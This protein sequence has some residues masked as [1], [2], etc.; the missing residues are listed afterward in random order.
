[1]KDVKSAL[2][3]IDR[4]FQKKKQ[5]VDSALKDIASG[6]TEIPDLLRIN[7]NLKTNH[8]ELEALL[9]D[10]YDQQD[11]VIRV[12]KE[13]KD[14]TIPLNI[15]HR[16]QEVEAFSERLD[17]IYEEFAELKQ[18]DQDFEGDQM[19]E[20]RIKKQIQG[21]DKLIQNAEKDRKD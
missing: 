10:A 15:N 3:K 13:H 14:C 16:Q 6:A 18:A 17:R 19:V 8:L 20:A 2:D 7:E 4:Q 5:D 9:N 11:E 12:K 1:M 21:I